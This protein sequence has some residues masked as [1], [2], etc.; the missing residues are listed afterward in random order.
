MLH[1]TFQGELVGVG[2]WAVSTHAACLA[3][4]GANPLLLP[5]LQPENLLMDEKVSRLA[6][7]TWHLLPVPP[8]DDEIL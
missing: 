7:R 3:L 5:W 1:K 8:L 2:E 6:C 4:Q